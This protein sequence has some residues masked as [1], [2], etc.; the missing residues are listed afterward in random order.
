MLK[1]VFE[2][3]DLMDYIGLYKENIFICINIFSLKIIVL[4]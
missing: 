4:R 2:N 1:F 3:E